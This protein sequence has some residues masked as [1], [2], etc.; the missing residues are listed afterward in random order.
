MPDPYA[1]KGRV[2]STTPEK[3]TEQDQFLTRLADLGATEDELD[4]VRD[5]WDEL[6]PDDTPDDPDLGPAWTLARRTE[7][8]HASD[9][10][11]TALLRRARIE[12]DEGTTTEDEADE[13]ERRREYDR[14]MAEATERIGGNVPSILGWVGDDLV[15]AQVVHQLETGEGG[16]NRST[17][18]EPLQAMLDAD[19]E[20]ADETPQ[21]AQ[22][23][24]EGDSGPDTPPEG[25][26]ASTDEQGP[27]G[28]APAAP[29]RPAPAVA[30]PG[31]DVGSR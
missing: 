11:L 28:E 12:H 19:A 26:E 25:S 27:T 16:A 13:Q 3:R 6:D 23:G 2:R 29:E 17:L 4:Q 22:D 8:T 7:L 5:A 15:R 31:D 9:H 18:V 21:G 20:Q 24:P 30:R 14:A 10:E 1:P